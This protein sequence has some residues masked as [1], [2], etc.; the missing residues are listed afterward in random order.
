[1]LRIRIKQLDQ[2][3]VQNHSE[4]FPPVREDESVGQIRLELFTCKQ[5]SIN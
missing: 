4:G 1:M 5:L 2:N 3:L